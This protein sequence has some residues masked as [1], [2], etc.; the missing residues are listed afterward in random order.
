MSGGKAQIPCHHGLRAASAASRG[1][2][3]IGA[4]ILR[5]EDAQL[6]VGRGQFVDDITLPG[7]LHAA[8]LRSPIAHAYVRAIDQIERLDGCRARRRRK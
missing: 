4:R 7:M 8:F 3:L 6:L 1:G 2:S 5:T